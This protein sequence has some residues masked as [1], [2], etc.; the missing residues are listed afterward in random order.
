MYDANTQQ[1]A[2]VEGMGA[3]AA[4]ASGAQQLLDL[5]TGLAGAG[6]GMMT[7]APAAGA[8]TGE[9][10]ID[11]TFD[12]SFFN[13]R[14][15]FNPETRQFNGNPDVLAAAPITVA[16][17]HTHSH[18]Y[19]HTYTHTNTFTHTHTHTHTHTLTGGCCCG[20]AS[21]PHLLV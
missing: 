5:I 18:T 12:T 6:W 2:G 20:H 17:T 19:T 9:R 7:A 1:Q 4:R 10:A 8:T 15:I 3:D 16:N 13:T 21:R 14:G 11:N